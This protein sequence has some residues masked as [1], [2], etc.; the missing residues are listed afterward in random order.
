MKRLGTESFVPVDR[1]II[2]K[3][4]K[5]KLCYITA[6]SLC[7]QREAKPASVS[8]MFFL[9]DM[10]T[11]LS[12]WL[13]AQQPSTIYEDLLRRKSGVTNGLRSA[14]VSRSLNRFVKRAPFL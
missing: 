5:K 13:C 8:A 1:F 12:L 10:A 11:M 3:K 9:P 14:E 7:R 2:K 4:K 6:Y